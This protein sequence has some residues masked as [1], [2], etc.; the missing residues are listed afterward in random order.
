MKKSLTL[1]FLFVSAN[2]FAQ[3]GS[4]RGTITDESS[5]EAL[6]GVTVS[7][8]ANGVVSD[9]AGNYIF[10]LPSGTQTIK[11]SFVGY[12]TL[13]KQVII[14]AGDTIKLNIELVTNAKELGTIVVSSSRY[15]K[16]ISE[17]TVS[18][19]VIKPSFIENTNSIDMKEAINK[20]PGVNIIDGQAN[21]R[22]GSGYSYG[23][24]SRVLVLVDDVPQLAADAGDVKW[25][26]LPLENLD[27]VE[28]I[29]G[30]ASSLYGSSALNGV[31]NI[32]TNYPTSVPKTQI[33]FYQGI[34][35]N[36]KRKEIIWWGNK[37]PYYS[38]GYF[39]HSQKFGQFDL[40]FGGNVFNES[41]F[42]EGEYTERGRVN[43]STRYR[44]KKIDGLAI[45]LNVNAFVSHTGTFFIWQ[46]DTTGAYRPQGGMDSATTS[47]AE[48]NN[49][50]LSI[51][52]YLTYFNKNGNRHSFH[53]RY[54]LTN[55]N[56]KDNKSTNAQLYYGEYQYQHFFKFGLNLTTGIAAN[57]SQI[58]ADLYGN[59]YADNEAL[60]LQL[61]QKKGRLNIVGGVRY[62][63][64]RV[65]T[66]T[67][68]SPI[69]I[70]AG[71][72]F[73]VMKASY[74]RASFGQGYRFPTIAE[75]FVATQ[76]GPLKIFPNP[77]VNPETGWS[78]EIGVKQGFK[79]SS[80]LGYLD[81]C[82]FMSEYK[83][84]MEFTFG[85]HPP[86]AW[87]PGDPINF[88]D[89]AKYLGFKTINITNAKISGGEFS[90]IGQGKLFGLPTNL[91][92]GVTYII[93]IDINKVSL[94][95]SLLKEN[96]GATKQ[97]LDSIS[98]I[99][100]LNYRYQWTAKAE[101]D[102][103]YH[104]FSTGFSFR[105]NSFMDNIDPIFNGT[106]PLVPIQ[107]VAGIVPYRQLHHTGD[108]VIDY[109]ISMKVNKYV[110][111]SLIIKNLMNREY[112]E[113]PAL[114]EQPRNFSLQ[115]SAKF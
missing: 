56:A 99:K 18:M 90:V 109:R 102:I 46:D 69:L 13:E 58:T 67:S 41:G 71:A 9:D 16:K 25:D 55:A 101:F 45:G 2:L 52:P 36:P 4:I 83:D 30:A 43:V 26:F 19:E 54:Y 48:N 72:N 34:Y 24:G 42:R 40:C 114:I 95:D 79:V 106:D 50:R 103:S 96:A 111:V 33:N 80:W 89:F 53:G 3:T 78:S 1:F 93:P 84:F 77:T 32:R 105:Y 5:D 44:F 6:I 98:K 91:L 92:A 38:G 104:S 64:F 31:I 49:T 74:F 107:V 86:Y 51:D 65:D 10:S 47:L 68:Q 73:R 22:G 113:R 39:T 27:Q 76:V 66:I 82:A 62:E 15:E 14:Q 63:M 35:Q 57:A 23:A 110:K 7:S 85:F 12:E 37:Q 61:D 60:F 11:F 59:H 108:Y 17:E 112:T 70:R 97:I 81:L 29:K 21:I 75:K 88:T 100:I 28:I 94:V 8:G 87:K 115:V 20:A